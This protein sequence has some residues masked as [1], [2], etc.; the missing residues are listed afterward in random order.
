MANFPLKPDAN[1]KLPE[2]FPEEAFAEFKI[3]NPIVPLEAVDQ[4]F[5]KKGFTTDVI[6]MRGVERLEPEVYYDPQS[7][8]LGLWFDKACHLRG[9]ARIGYTQSAAPS[10]NEK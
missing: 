10:Q 2:R 9:V 1:F 6:T 5:L 3:G 8:V 4:Y 7:T